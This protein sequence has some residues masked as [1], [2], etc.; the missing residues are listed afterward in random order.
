[1]HVT[2]PNC[3]A[4]YAVEPAAL[5]PA[6]RTVQCVRCSHRWFETPPPPPP[7][8]PPSPPPEPT[9]HFVIRPTTA[10]S[11]LPVVAKPPP[12]PP[13]PRRSAGTWIAVALVL[14]IACGLGA[15][16]YRD[17][18]MRRLPPEW[19]ALLSADLV[20]GLIASPASAA[21][22]ATGPRARLRVDG[23]A[24]RIDL[25]EGRYVLTGEIVNR[26][27][28]PGTPHAMQLVFR[29]ADDSVLGERTLALAPEALAP[30]A[31]T[32]FALPLDE[33]PAGTSTLL[34]TIE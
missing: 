13:P 26:G 16:A 20:R 24:S 17:D 6:G 3:A 9:P 1:M 2:C 5:G 10:G 33:P 12:L 7:G 27:S 18:L 11:G 23:A 8:L 34:P 28:A 25:I 22:P 29:A 19:R 15:Y 14:L 4:R 21:R 30:G 32:R 31:R